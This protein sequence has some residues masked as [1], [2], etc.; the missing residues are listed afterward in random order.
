[1]NIKFSFFF[2]QS[3]TIHIIRSSFFFFF[4]SSRGMHAFLETSRSTGIRK[5]NQIYLL[6]IIK[7]HCCFNKH[8]TYMFLLFVFH[9]NL[10]TYINNNIYIL[11]TYVIQKKIPI[12]KI[13]ESRFLF[14]MY[15]YMYVYS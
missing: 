5:W 12:S 1:M 9:I 10:Y 13:R 3:F 2:N 14:F 4:F 15:Y 8:K 11:F 7:L 6:H